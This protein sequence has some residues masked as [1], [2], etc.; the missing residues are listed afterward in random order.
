MRP[1]ELHP[2]QAVTTL[3]PA[4]I[5]KNKQLINTC[6]LVGALVG[7]GHMHP[8]LDSLLFYLV[9]F[10]VALFSFARNAF[11]NVLL[12]ASSLSYMLAWFKGFHDVDFNLMFCVSGL[13]CLIYGIS[14]TVRFVLTSKEVSKAEIFALVNCYLIM[15]F[16][17][18]LLYTLVEGIHPGSFNL[19]IHTERIMDSMI[20]FSFATM[21]TVGYGD[22]APHT[23]LAQ[24]L[25]ITQAIFGQ[26]YFALVVAYLLN[27]LFQERREASE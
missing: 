22:M 1:Q 14:S 17:W 11:M 23:L 10:G 6:M 8:L 18:A 4:S 25:A 2:T 26:F 9:I 20:Y 21:T 5:A 24:R 3:L 16:F 7:G 12:A 27:R 19:P 15:G 13:L